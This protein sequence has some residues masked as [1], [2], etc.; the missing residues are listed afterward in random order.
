MTRESPFA[1]RGV[2]EGF[3]GRPWTHDQRLDMVDFI[4][5]RG[6]NTFVYSPKDDPLVRQHWRR[7]YDGEELA[8]LS[9]LLEHCRSRGV[10]LVFCLSPGL[11]IEYSSDGDAAI[12]SDKFAAIAALGVT[13]FG[14][15][16]D[17]IPHT[18]QHPSDSESFDNLVDA[19][20]RL[21]GRVFRC[22]E[23]SSRLFVC[24]T[25]YSGYGDED[26]IAQLGRGI[27]P[28][29]E[30]FWT[31]RA[32]CS[33][34]ID[35]ADAA[36]FA[37]ATGRLATYWDNYPVNDVAMK[38]EL[39][40]G[41]YRGRDPHLFRFATGV[42]ANGMELFESSKIAIATIAD[43]LAN[44][45]DYDSE[46]SWQSALR[47]VAG[48]ADVEAFALFADT[49]RL[50]CLSEDDAPTFT[51]AWESFIFASQYGDRE[52]AAVDLSVL[53]DRMRAAADHLLRG[54]VMNA[55][56]IAEARPWIEAFSVGVE[57]VM[58]IAELATEGRLAPDG[59]TELTTFLRRLREAR[60]RVFGDT[61]EMALAELTA[62]SYP[63]IAQARTE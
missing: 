46:S 57:A 61:L 21:I 31:G 28:R 34:T 42:I 63:G 6:M 5:A 50:S 1:I 15:L 16:L 12:L 54:P 41:P 56:L 62:K 8:R 44:P 29:I 52:K 43:Y 49:V 24:P 59:P 30:L 19:H 4:A 3:Y 22:L 7:R 48:S 23:Q 33:A 26:Y 47:D 53:A 38:N 60:V 25:T 14:L 27:D 58:R 35:L 11:S 9:E 10:D 55:A 20:V 37:R 39:H 40:I 36:T 2:V 51:C 32:I 17:D 18:L 45:E 13:S